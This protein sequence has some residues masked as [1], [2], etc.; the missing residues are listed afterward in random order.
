[1]LTFM[2]MLTSL[3]TAAGVIV[4][5][6]LVK[7]LI[8]SSFL[9]NLFSIYEEYFCTPEITLFFRTDCGLSDNQMYDVASTYLRTKI[10]DSSKCLNVGKTV[11]QERSTFDIVPGAEVID[12]FQGIK[13]L[14]WK[15]HVEKGFD[16]RECR[17]YFTLSFDK[18]L[19]EVVLESYLAEVIS[20]SKAIQ[21]AERVLKLYSRD[22]VWGTP[23]R[24][25]SSIVLEH[26][27]TFEKLAMDPVQ[28]RMLKDDLDK[29]V[30]RKEWYKKVGKAWKR[31]YL[32]YGPPGTGKSSLIAAMANYLKFDVYDLDLSRIRSDSEL[33]TIFLSTSNRS[34]M[35]IEDIDCAKLED[36]DREIEEMS[37][38]LILKKPKFTLSG[39]LNFI[40]GVWS[41]C[42]EG[43]I[44]VFTTNNKEKLEKLDPALLRPGRMD[45]HVH[46]SYLTM[47][48]FKQLVS[49]YLGIDGDHQLFEVIVGLLEDK[50]VT[51]AEIAEELLKSEDPNVA[52]RG[53]VEFLEQK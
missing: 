33:R 15:L 20:R 24:E 38:Q 12:S 18:K 30:N 17:R 8:P 39:L 19:K 32:L 2:E 44:I 9:N 46:M 23:G 50:K 3:I 31:G 4:L 26:P 1:M 13:G 47:D 34:I 28:K 16:G 52:L 6:P 27:T 36:R 51:P 25:W 21:E 22:Y 29:F 37:D 10:V 48:G 35:V 53:V 40:D 5:C 41:S 42:G 11:R 7:G 45:M 49:N 43:R 14:K